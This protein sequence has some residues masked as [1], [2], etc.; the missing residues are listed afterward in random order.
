MSS[1]HRH[2]NIIIAIVVIA[3]LILGVALIRNIVEKR[4]E[5]ARERIEDVGG[6]NVASGGSNSAQSA[7]HSQSGASGSQASNESQENDNQLAPAQQ[8][9]EE[10]GGGLVPVDNP[11]VS[12]DIIDQNVTPYRAAHGTQ[13]AFQA[14]ING[15]ATVVTMTI[16]G[17]GGGFT[18]SLTSGPYVP[19]H[20]NWAAEAMGPSM[21]GEYSYSTTARD[22]DGVPVQEQGSIFIV[23]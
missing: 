13:R 1:S 20:T 22:V 3:V 12:L 7:Q 18:V 16:A 15:Q 5:T 21:P 11:P 8:P 6:R 17:P 14:S 9:P 23:E 4:R 2:R 19:G 10:E